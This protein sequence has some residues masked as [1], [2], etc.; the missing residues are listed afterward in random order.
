MVCLDLLSCG[1]DTCV[2]SKLVSG[3]ASSAGPLGFSAGN[4]TAILVKNLFVQDATGNTLYSNSLTNMSALED[5]STGTNH[6]GACFG[7][8]M[9]TACGF[10]TLTLC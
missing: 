8:C 6:Y 3:D 7:K 9:H 2:D 5:F 4:D 1:P 10:S